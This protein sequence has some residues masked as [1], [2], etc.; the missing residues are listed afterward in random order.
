MACLV[1]PYEYGQ[2]DQSYVVVV[3]VVVVLVRVQVGTN[4]HGM[5]AVKPLERRWSRALLSRLLV[6]II[7]IIVINIALT[8]VSFLLNQREQVNNIVP[9]RCPISRHAKR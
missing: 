3:V 2:E 7:F 8:T 4:G 6:A 9:A 5:Y 1:L